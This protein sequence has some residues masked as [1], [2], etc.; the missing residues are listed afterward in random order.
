MPN[1]LDPSSTWSP[2]KWHQL[3]HVCRRWR[4]LVFAS[5][6]RLDLRVVYTF[7]RKAR[8]VKKALGRRPTLPIAVWYPSPCTIREDENN[9]SFALQHPDRIREISLFLTDS[10]LFKTRAQLLASFPALEY[11]RLE[12]PDPT[13]SESPPL[14]LGFLGSSAP[15]LSHIHLIG[16]PFPTLPLLLLSTRDLVSLQL[17]SVSKAG[18]FSPE[19]LSI[20]LSMM[21][22]LKSL[23]IHFLPL[24]SRETG[25]AGRPPPVR[26]TLPALT[27]FHFSGDKAYL[28]DLIS[29]LDSP[30]LEQ[31]LNPSAFET[32]RLAQFTS[33]PS[34]GVITHQYFLLLEDKIFFIKHCRTSSILNKA[35]LYIVS[36]EINSKATLPYI[37]TRHSSNLHAVQRIDMKSFLPK[38]LWLDPDDVDSAMWVVFFRQLVNVGVLELAGVFVQIVGSVLERLPEGSEVVRAVLPALHDLHVGK[39][40]KRGPFDNFAKTRWAI[41]VHH[42]GRPKQQGKPIG[43]FAFPPGKL[44]LPDS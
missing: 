30:I 7:K 39:C 42:A 12:S 5:P 25:N 10:L 17:D 43:R 32:Q 21:T 26:A 34:S 4:F 6:Q 20:G 31:S 22:Q 18:Y 35:I 14:P 9:A 33:R 38:S 13:K 41:T 24:A 23:I 8:V 28:D 27:K 29:R 16:V 37:F 2:W 44:R 15:R 36:E 40:E 3:A 11:L 1:S 19:T